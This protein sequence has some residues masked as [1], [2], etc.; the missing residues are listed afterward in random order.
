MT[1]KQLLAKIK[2]CFALAASCNENE[3]AAALE[4]ARALMDAHGVGEDELALSDIE[5]ATARASRT[6]RPPMWESYLSSA[7]CRAMNVV[8]FI[9]QLGDRTFVGRGAAPDVATYA[10]TVLFRQLKSQRKLYV[11]TTLRR[12]GLA[13]KRQRAD[14]FCQ[15]WALAVFSKIAAIVPKA[16]GD[17]AFDRYLAE[18]H[19]GLT[20]VGARGASSKGRRTDQDYWNGH[21]AGAAVNLANGVGAGI[22]PVMLT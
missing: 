14:A 17:P 9:N 20:T 5:E 10:F 18:R 2:K 22:A 16:D 1:R 11:A 8:S 21:D 15:G 19:P 13:R 3:A 4:K 12:C 6:M 7:V